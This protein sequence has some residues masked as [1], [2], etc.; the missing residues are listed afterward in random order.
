[1]SENKPLQA[2]LLICAKWIIPVDGQRQTL[3]DHALLIKD[4]KILAILEQAEARRRVNA[5]Q[6]LQLDEHLLI[7]GLINAHGHAPMSLLRGVADDLPLM[8]WLEGHIWPIENKFVSEDFVYHGASLAIAE[9]I[10]SGTTCFADM[11]FFPQAVAKAAQEAQIR[12]QLASP[13]LDFASAW[14]LDADDY[15]RKTTDLVDHYRNSNLVSVAFGP[16]APYTVSDEPLKKLSILAEELDL[17]IHIHIHETAEEVENALKTT[18]KRP[19]QRLA[20]LGLISPRLLCVHATQ[21]SAGDMQLLKQHGASVIHCPESNLK[22]ASGFCEVE[23]LHQLGINIALG[24]DGCASNND[25]DMFSE[26]RTAALLGKAVAGN[27]KAIPAFQALE[28]ATINGAKALGLEDQ[29]G[30]LEVGKFAD[31]TAVRMDALNTLPIYN[32]ISQLV[33]SCNASQVSHVW[34]GGQ[35]LYKEGEHITVDRHSLVSNTRQ[36]QTR[37]AEHLLTLS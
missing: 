33:Y 18:G 32:P 28:M 31:I 21:L 8:E 11:Y 14:G 7:P 16:H 36:W 19:L 10:A 20:D 24:T 12:V 34:C 37:I 4:G 23:K 6:T 35:I 1:M 9:M 27:A 3:E 29:I 22:L 15:I 2:D 30:S 5:K 25:L 13:I 26:M 17:P